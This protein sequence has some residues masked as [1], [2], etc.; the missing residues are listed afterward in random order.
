MRVGIFSK[1]LVV[2][3]PLVEPAADRKCVAD[4][5]PLRLAVKAEHFAEVVHQTGQHKP[6]FVS[7][8]TNRLGGLQQVLKLIEFDVGV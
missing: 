3:D 4:N 6:V 8:G 1:K 2:N 7:V 5:R